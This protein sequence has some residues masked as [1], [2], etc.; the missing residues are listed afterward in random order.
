MPP[1][2]LVVATA[3]DKKIEMHHPFHTA[4]FGLLFRHATVAVSA[5]VK[6]R[7]MPILST[8]TASYWLKLGY[9]KGLMMLEDR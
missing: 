1:R 4:S 9:W 6:N 7:A 2:G 3:L 5:F 8:E